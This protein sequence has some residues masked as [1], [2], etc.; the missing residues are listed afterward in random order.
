[1]RA[2]LEED[3]LYRT[4]NL[5]PARE[6]VSVS[7]MSSWSGGKRHCKQVLTHFVSASDQFSDLI[8]GRFEAGVFP[9]DVAVLVCAGCCG[10]KVWGVLL[11]ASNDPVLC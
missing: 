8:A 5:F 1:M 3:S 4:L 6:K 2:V 7:I 10:G 11:S 9:L